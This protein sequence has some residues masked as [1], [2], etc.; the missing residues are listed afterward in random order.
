MFLTSSSG[1]KPTVNEH[2]PIPCLPTSRWPSMLL[3]APKIGGCG[4]WSGLGST[5]RGAP[6]C[7]NSP[8]AWY[9]S[10]VHA[11]TMCW[12]ASRHIARVWL[13]S[14]AKPSSSARVDERP[15]PKSTRPSEIRSST[16][17]DSA[18]RIGWL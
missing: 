12:R 5:R 6:M 13:G 9:S 4:F 2:R 3:V 8:S 1:G 7:Q 15:V 11:P 17:A 18:E 14:T 16:A 10:S